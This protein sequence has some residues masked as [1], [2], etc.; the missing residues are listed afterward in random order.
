MKRKYE[1]LFNK[2]NQSYFAV[3]S[4]TGIIIEGS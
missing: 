2:E 4:R 3:K 1:I